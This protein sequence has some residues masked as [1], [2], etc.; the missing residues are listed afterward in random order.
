MQNRSGHV[1]K[2]KHDAQLTSSATI[3]TFLRNNRMSRNIALEEV[4][5]S[6]G[7]SAAILKALE[8]EDR[9]QLPAEVYIKAFYRKY[10]EY[11]G[12]KSEEI[13]TRYDQEEQS[14]K[15]VGRKSGFSTVITLKGKEENLFIEI[16]RR[17]FLPFVIIVIGVLIYWIYKNYLAPNNP[18]GFY[19]KNFSPVCRHLL[20]S[21]SELFC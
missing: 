5:E 14:P 19:Q 4:S 17:L 8:N 3:G 15:K 16:L 13:Q 12:L 18:L 21:A 10:A 2:G 1:D 6:T 7:I 9:E 11:L 20:S